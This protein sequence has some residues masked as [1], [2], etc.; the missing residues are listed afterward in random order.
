MAAPEPWPGGPWLRNP[1]MPSPLLGGSA[2]PEGPLG[3]QP[4]PQCLLR[5]PAVRE[6]AGEAA[7]GLLGEPLQGAAAPPGTAGSLG[8][9]RVRQLLKHAAE[10]LSSPSR[11]LSS[12]QQGRGQFVLQAQGVLLS[13]WGCSFAQ[14]SAGGF[15]SCGQL[16]PACGPGAQGRAASS[17]ACPASH[18]GFVALCFPSVGLRPM[19]QWYQPQPR[20]SSHL[21]PAGTVGIRDL[22]SR[23]LSLQG[24]PEPCPTTPRHPTRA[25][26]RHR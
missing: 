10:K 8:F 25:A 1:A 13:P 15:G 21:L 17:T 14:G 22:S 12:L 6:G 23:H 2:F 20:L 19:P 9:G 11:P 18:Q 4:L 5:L 16:L 3:L 26:P 24:S 7:R